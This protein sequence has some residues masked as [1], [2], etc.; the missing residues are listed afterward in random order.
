MADIRSNY[1]YLAGTAMDGGSVT[2]I[3]YK[4]N[5]RWYSEPLLNIIAAAAQ[6][7]SF[8][9]VELAIGSEAGN[10]G[11][12][13]NV[14]R[15]FNDPVGVE[16]VSRTGRNPQYTYVQLGC[17]RKAEQTM[18][19]YAFGCVGKPFDHLAMLRSIVWPRTS[20]DSSFYCAELVASILQ[21]GGLLSSSSNPGSATPESL[22]RLYS[23]RAAVTANPWILRDVSAV[24]KLTATSLKAAPAALGLRQQTSTEREEQHGLVVRKALADANF[25]KKIGSFTV[26]AGRSSAPFQA[27]SST[28][29]IQLSLES[30][31]M[32]TII[33]R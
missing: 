20:D 4:I 32:R 3:F 30:L 25:S 28:T 1:L 15:V 21:R 7:S 17:S 11:Q 5:E 8:T 19:A 9:H 16:L 18:L 33:N 31:N 2:L 26:V 24:Q 27:V 10:Q 22:H 12:I 6:N 13:T 29:G 14:A 23:T